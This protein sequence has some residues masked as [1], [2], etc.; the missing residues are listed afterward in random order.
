MRKKEEIYHD[1]AAAGDVVNGGTVAP[2]PPQNATILES[3]RPN[4][5][6][7]S[8]YMTKLPNLVAVQPAAFEED[9]YIPEEE[10]AQ[11]KG[12][13]H[14]MIRWRYQRDKDGEI[15]RKDDGGLARESNTRLVQW[16]DGSYTLHIGN[17]AFDIQTVDSS[18]NG[19]AGLNGY[20]Y[21]SQKATF[22]DADDME[23]DTPSGTVLEGI[24]P[25]TSRLIAK[26][27]SLQSEAH[28]SLTVAVRQRTIKTARIA[29]YVTQED[30]EKAKAARIR[31]KEDLEKA[32]A[33]KS[34]YYRP[35]GS[36]PRQPGMN[37]RYLEEEEDDEDYDTTNI[38]KLKKGSA[39]D[40]DID[41][42]GDESDD[43]GYET[44]KKGRDRKRRQREEEE[45][46]AAEEE[47]V[48]DEESDEDEGT[49]IK[50]HK[51]TKRSHQA[52]VDDD[53]DE[54]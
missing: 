49:L 53:D 12:Y 31:N 51:K 28:K 43:D 9:L 4:N 47:L 42:Y 22:N 45:D 16:S 2:K 50:A 37:R 3:Y 26:P 44:F 1:D 36:R 14:N 33:R 39:M 52:V 21:L 27:S 7:I 20:V 35:T 18:S 32:T 5:K 15:I 11:Y 41:D 6:D 30:P 29:E 25:V 54:D 19:F 8:M 40:D 46:D 48:F 38:R 24:G 17:E 10:E 13:V 23:E 34:S